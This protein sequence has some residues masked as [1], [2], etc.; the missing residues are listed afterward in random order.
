MGS[1]KRE[2]GLGMIESRR[3]PAGGGVTLG[4]ILAEIVGGVIRIMRAVII[5]LVA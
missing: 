5:I 4:A 1:R 3:G 2:L